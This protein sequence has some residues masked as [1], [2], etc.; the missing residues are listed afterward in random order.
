[1]YYDDVLCSMKKHLVCVGFM[2]YLSHM[3]GT[4]LP[5]V[6]KLL[7]MLRLNIQVAKTTVFIVFF[8]K[9]LEFEEGN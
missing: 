9:P 6:C 5:C 3:E 2:Q 8:W 1:M 7:I 4:E